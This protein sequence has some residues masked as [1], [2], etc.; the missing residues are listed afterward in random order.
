[1]NT[2]QISSTPIAPRPPGGAWVTNAVAL[3]LGLG[4]ATVCGH[5]ES[6]NF[7]AGNDTGWTRYSPL[8]PFG[9][10]VSYSFPNGGYR[11]SL[12]AFN[13]ARVGYSRGGSFLEGTTYSEF[14]ESVNITDWSVGSFGL[15]ARVGNLGLGRT[16]GYAFT[17]STSHTMEIAFFVG[18][19]A[20]RDPSATVPVTLDPQKQYQLTFDGVGNDLTGKIFDLADPG[21][22]LA[23]VHYTDRVTTLIP[24]NVDHS[25]YASGFSGL[26]LASSTAAPAVT[27]DNFHVSSTVPEP[28]S[29][30]MAS[31]CSI[32][33]L[34]A[35][36]WIQRRRQG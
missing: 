4:A 25:P 35:W 23:T 14:H 17:Y 34:A 6:Y 10:S 2:K 30:A 19:R 27:F 11:M 12:P 21:T 5:A 36:H 28:I 31:G 8:A 20:W 24:D 22:A 16:T 1:M 18:E 3:L 13:N 26:V 32:F 9:V 29:T 7:D 15:A 33:A